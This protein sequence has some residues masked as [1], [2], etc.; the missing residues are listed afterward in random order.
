MNSGNQ[1]CDM[2]KSGVLT[3]RLEAQQCVAA[4]VLNRVCE[5]VHKKRDY[6][7][8]DSIAR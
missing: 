8:G 3:E 5:P 2:K 4:A 6:N 1:T 7:Y